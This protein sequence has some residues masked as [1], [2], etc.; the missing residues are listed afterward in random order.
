MS[1]PGLFVITSYSI[2][3]TKLYDYWP[4]GLPGP[5]LEGGDNPVV[6]VTDDTGYSRDNWYVLNSDFQLDIDIPG[7][8]GLSV[9]LSASLDKS[10][11][12]IKNWST[13]WTV[14]NIDSQGGVDADGNPLL[15][16]SESR[17]NFV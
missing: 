16:A 10:F 7:V 6:L 2:H 11:Q 8:D 12:F 13:P 1:I 4:N 5:G 17:N 3:Y 9:A 14:Y 15:V